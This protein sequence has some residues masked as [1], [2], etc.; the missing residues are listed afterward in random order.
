MPPPIAPGIDALA[1]DWLDDSVRASSVRLTARLG[2]SAYEALCEVVAAADQSQTF[3]TLMAGSDFFVDQAGRQL[4]WLCDALADGTLLVAREWTTEQWDAALATLCGPHASES[5]CLAALRTFRHRHLV[6]IIWREVAQL[7]TVEDTFAELSGLADC[8][9]RAAV[10]FAVSALRPKYGLP[11]GQESGDEQSLVVLAMGKL[12]GNELNLSSDIDLIFAYPEA[13]E[14][15]GGKQRLANQTYFVRLGQLVIRLL[16]AVTEDGFAFRVDMRLRPYGDSGALVGAFSALELYYQEQGREWERYAMVKARPITGTAA[17]K[18]SLMAM[19]SAFVYRRYTDFSVIAALRSMK[20]MMRAEVTRLGIEA[21]VKR[22]SGGIREIEFIAQSLQ[23][24]HG[25]RMPGLRLQSLLPTLQAL[26][27]ADVLPTQ[28]GQ[29]L[30]DHYR[31]LRRVEHGLQGMADRQ[32]QALPT[33]PLDKAKLAILVGYASWEAL[34]GDLVVARG[35]VDAVFSALIADPND[36]SSN[37]LVVSQTRFSALNAETLTVLGYRH[38]GLTWETV[39]SLLDS[40]WVASLQGEGRQRF[41][42]FLPLLCEMAAHEANPDNALTRALPFVRAVCRRSAYLVLLQENPAAL[43]HLLSLVAASTWV[44]DRLASRPEL[45]DELLH[46]AQLFSAPSRDEIKALVRQQL[47]RIPE[48]DLEG[49]MGALSRIKEGAI[50]RVAASELSGTLPVMQVSDN[51]TF[52]AEV[53]IEQAIAVARAE[54]VQRHGEPQAEQ[55]GFAVM[56]YGKLGGIELSYGSDLDL[57]FV[58]NGADGQTAGPKVIDNSRFYTRL[59]QRVTHVLSAQMFSGR[60]YEVDLRLRPDGDSGLVATTL[61]GFRRYQLESAWTWEHQALVRSRTV[62]G[63]PSLRASLEQLRR[64][65]LTM[66]RDAL[67]L[68]AAVRDMRHKMLTEQVS[69]NRGVER[70]DIKRDQGGIVDIEFVVQYLVLAH[71]SEYPALAQWSDVIRLLETLEQ[72]GVLSADQAAV[73]SSRYLI[74]RSALH[75]LALQGADTQVEA[76][77]HVAGRE[78]VKRVTEALL[79]GLQAT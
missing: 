75:G 2:S 32:T 35:E 42:A 27:Q 17:A 31:L 36:Q 38:P 74:Y 14:T 11:I 6:R 52:L 28:Q 56:A 23:L 77:A 65:V 10:A 22:G 30:S 58:F 12:G 5:D 64:E 13:G 26:M 16:D 9:I 47:L 4:A 21:D 46:E 20:S 70:F 79:P 51:L 43:K 3:R 29:R 73:L 78:Q 72:V 53:M 50:L 8:C 37:E 48:E 60:L 57:V 39:G 25:G 1:S 61:T 44:A 67:V 59:A 66:P 69:M 7:A 19:L 76:G 41:E 68:S 49:Q 55:V 71:A 33:E 18:T 54:L 63:D 45:L 24:I 34:D 62:A 40:P 15:E